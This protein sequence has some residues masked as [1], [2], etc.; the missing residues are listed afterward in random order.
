MLTVTVGTIFEDSKIP[1]HKWLVA[2]YLLNASKKGISALQIQRMLGL[3]SYRTLLIFGSPFIKAS[4]DTLSRS[5]IIVS[6][7]VPKSLL[8]A[9][10]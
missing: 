10:M 4:G 1:L 8:P 9:S 3:G 7:E 2:W 5:M 6:V